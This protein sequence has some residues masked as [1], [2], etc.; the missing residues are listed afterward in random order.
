MQRPLANLLA[1]DRERAPHRAFDWSRAETRED[2]L[3]VPLADV[4]TASSALGLR[5]GDRKGFVTQIG[6]ALA[7][8]EALKANTQSVHLFM[9]THVEAVAGDCALQ[10]V[11]PLPLDVEEG[12]A[13]D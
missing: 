9:G 5:G 12:S 7:A 8:V 6:G 13:G 4:Q 3:L 11:P 10:N 2:S 1:G